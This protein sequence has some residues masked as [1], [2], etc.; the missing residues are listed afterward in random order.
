ATPRGV[1][2]DPFDDAA[3]EPKREELDLDDLARRLYPRIR[4]YLRKELSIDRERAALVLG[5]KR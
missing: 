4:P 1:Q 3:P 5:A 2:R